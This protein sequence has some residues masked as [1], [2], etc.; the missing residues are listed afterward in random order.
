MDETT[1]KVDMTRNDLSIIENKKKSLN[2]YGKSLVSHLQT[3]TV[4]RKLYYVPGFMSLIC[5]FISF[6]SSIDKIQ[7]KLYSYISLNVPKETKDMSPSFFSSY[8]IE[9]QIKNKKQIV[10]TLDADEINN[11]KKIELIKY[12][13]R[14][15]K[16]TLDTS[17]IL[18]IRFT[19]DINYGTLVKLIDLCYADQH[20]RFVLL[21]NSFVIF[22]ESPLKIRESY[23]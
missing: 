13:A 1:N 6:K 18:R 7:P 2:K 3:M 17:T 10:L 20:K 8:W 19:N 12:E 15:L 23:P 9:K 4:K 11:R 16:Y 21:K 22:G 5:L 14:K